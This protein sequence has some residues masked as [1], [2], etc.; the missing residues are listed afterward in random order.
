MGAFSTRRFAA[1]LR[2]VVA[3]LAAAVLAA[4]A[5]RAHA[6]DQ[7]P[8][9]PKLGPHSEAVRGHDLYRNGALGTQ[10]LT[11]NTDDR[12]SLL[13]AYGI[14]LDV[15]PNW[16]GEMKQT[17]FSTFPGSNEFA[18][19]QEVR[20]KVSWIIQRSYPQT[21][22]TQVIEAADVSGLTEQEAI[23]ATQAAIWHLTDAFSFDGLYSPGEAGG[24]TTSERTQRVRKL[25]EYLLG[26]ANTGLPESSGPSVQV[27]TP[28]VAGATGGLVGPI[29]LASTQGSVAVAKL[30]YPLVDAQGSEV[31]SFAVPTGTD[32]FLNVPADAPAG[33]AAIVAGL[34]GNARAGQLLVPQSG[35]GQAVIIARGQQVTA[36]G[37]GEI[38]WDPEGVPS[39]IRATV[40]V[41]PGLPHAGA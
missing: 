32:L 36:T 3:A 35:R 27:A 2:A 30:P 29:R 20:S 13:L 19:N 38:S 22:I 16:G 1:G 31:D 40:P 10:L 26:P 8:G 14:E 4:G 37:R 24:D 6:D 39:P 34:V 23:T 41:K 7:Q 33:K 18:T 5:P 11:V 9:Y 17:G 12:G 21:D 25:Y 28:A 15:P